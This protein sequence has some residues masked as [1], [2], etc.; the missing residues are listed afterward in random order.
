MCCRM[1]AKRKKKKRHWNSFWMLG[2]EKSVADIQK[3]HT[4]IR[5]AEAATPPSDALPG[6]R[7]RTPLGRPAPLQKRR[8]RRRERRG[9]TRKRRMAP[10]RQRRGCRQPLP[11]FMSRGF[12]QLRDHLMSVQPANAPPHSAARSWYSGMCLRGVRLGM[13]RA[14]WALPLVLT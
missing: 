4:E 7:R 14:Y 13:I 8:G 5:Q 1:S 3:V 9:P 2:L 12:P 11:R 6:I 10:P